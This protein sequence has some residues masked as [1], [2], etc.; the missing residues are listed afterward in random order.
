MV[1]QYRSHVIQTY[2]GRNQQTRHPGVG[3]NLVNKFDTPEW[4][5]SISSLSC[6]T[7]VVVTNSRVSPT[8]NMVN[9]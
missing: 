6:F 9:S 1:M 4:L 2:R 7:T 3:H 8:S 5:N